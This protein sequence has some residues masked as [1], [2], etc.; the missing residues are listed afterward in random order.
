MTKRKKPK[1]TKS[2]SPA[3]S[4]RSKATVAVSVALLLIL[5]LVAWMLW[6][7]PSGLDAI[8]AE[9]E[10]VHYGYEPLLLHPNSKIVLEGELPILRWPKQAQN[11]AQWLAAECFGFSY[12]VYEELRDAPGIESVALGHASLA[13][14][15]GEDHQGNSNHVVAVVTHDDGRIENVDL[16]PLGIGENPQYNFDEIIT[17]TSAI[18]MQFQ[19]M[20]E[21]IPINKIFPM[22]VV[23]KN[24]KNYYVMAGM[25]F[26]DDGTGYEIQ[27]RVYDFTPATETQTL[28]FHRGMIAGF[29]GTF[30]NH[31]EL[32]R[33]INENEPVDIHM[34][35][36]VDDDL[37][38]IVD[39]NMHLP[40]AIVN[41]LDLSSSLQ[42]IEVTVTPDPNQPFEMTLKFRVTDAE[43]DAPLPA[44]VIRVN[45]KPLEGRDYQLFAANGQEVNIPVT[46][47]LL[48]YETWRQNVLFVA[49]KTASRNIPAPIQLKRSVP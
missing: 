31:A 18:R 35:G 4:Y 41:K 39:E 19:H 1:R 11:Q 14:R 24:G 36:D 26:Y 7:S 49:E 10:N 23:E 16:T 47:E 9:L 20:R 6:P 22:K 29:I 34:R 21:G 37:K 43:T 42:M 45:K 27:L 3:P 32:K 8:A 25:I 46:V 28:Q 30:E 40:K 15:L 44:A 33:K 12:G 48:G 38:A 13:S 5:V 2:Q 17:D